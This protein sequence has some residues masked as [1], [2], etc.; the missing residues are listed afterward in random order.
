MSIGK[1]P[2]GGALPS[3]REPTDSTNVFMSEPGIRAL[4][5]ALPGALYLTDAAGRIIYCNDAA[6][7]IWGSAPELGKA[8]WIGPW[9]LFWP[10][11]SP[12]SPEQSPMARALKERRPIRGMEVIGEP[13][14]SSGHKSAPHCPR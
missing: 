8:Q 14:R 9:K 10:D 5:D 2:P 12:V 3:L 7:E 11:G 6:V 13:I 4:L 1:A